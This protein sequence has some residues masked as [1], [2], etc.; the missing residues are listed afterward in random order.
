MCH[1]TLLS[2]CVRDGNV[3]R[4]IELT[5]PCLTLVQQLGPDAVELMTG[6]DIGKSDVRAVPRCFKPRANGRCLFAFS[7][8][9]S[10]GHVEAA[11]AHPTISIN[12]GR[13]CQ[14]V[15]A[16]LQYASCVALNV[17]VAK[18]KW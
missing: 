11:F 8:L 10:M 9:S 13:R 12:P 7:S 6:A 16:L 4:H 2:M 3:A 1:S 18:R 15:V 5:T 17:I 14:E